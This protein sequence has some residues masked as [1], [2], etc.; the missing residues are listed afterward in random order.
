MVDSTKFLLNVFN[1]K[2]KVTFV[3]LDG[4]PCNVL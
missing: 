3:I 4:K 2:Q 1:S